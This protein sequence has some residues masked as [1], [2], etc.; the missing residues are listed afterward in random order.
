MHLIVNVFEL[1]F[2]VAVLA[3]KL[4]YEQKVAYAFHPFQSNI[5]QNYAR[6]HILRGDKGCN[7]K[8]IKIKN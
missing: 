7:P 8:K 6:P 4:V 5:C 3:L 1:S 2:L